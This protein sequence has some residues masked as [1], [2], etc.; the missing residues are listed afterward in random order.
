[1]LLSDGIGMSGP[2]PLPPPP[3]PPLEEKEGME[4]KED[5]SVPSTSSRHSIH[6]CVSGILQIIY[7]YSI[8][9]I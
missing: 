5:E 6:R 4:E 9:F 3:P 2:P 8:Q 7:S 1:M